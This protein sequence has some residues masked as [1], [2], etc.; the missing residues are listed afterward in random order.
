LFSSLL[1]VFV[2]T[3]ARSITT[4]K[5]REVQEVKDSLISLASHQLRTPATGVKQFVGMVLEGYVGDINP[6]QKKM[7]EKAYTSNER[8]LEIINQILH[9]TR[10]DSGRLVIQKEKINIVDVIRSVIDE[11]SQTI[12]ARKQQVVFQSPAYGIYIQGDKQYLAMAIDNLLT[13]A[14]KY[15][16]RHKAI[17]ITVKRTKDSVVITVRDEGVGIDSKDMHLLFQKFSRIHNELSVEAG[18]NGIGL[19]LCKEIITL[20]NGHISVNSVPQNGTKFDVTL[21]KET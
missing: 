15:S 5:N 18:G 2:T 19:Y 10:A 13:N 12:Q 20:H 7:L 8:Q 4:E 17:H 9:V 21:P 14:S 1:F 6:D 3:R 11:Y 16:H